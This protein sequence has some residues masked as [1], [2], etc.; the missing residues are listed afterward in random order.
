MQKIR[1]KNE[2]GGITMQQ[3]SGDGYLEVL[4]TEE[5]LIK[6][7]ERREKERRKEPEKL[8]REARNLVLAGIFI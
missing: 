1:S 5:Y 7:K 8:R 2:N 6:R 4:S 3:R